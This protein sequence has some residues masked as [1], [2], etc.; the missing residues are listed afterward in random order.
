MALSHTILL[1]DVVDLITVGDSQY[2]LHEYSDI[3]GISQDDLISSAASVERKTFYSDDEY[4]FP[5]EYYN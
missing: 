2:E 3:T 5:D 4:I 1:S